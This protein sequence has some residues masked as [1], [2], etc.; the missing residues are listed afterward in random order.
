MSHRDSIIKKNKEL[1]KPMD[2]M[3]VG[4]TGNVGSGGGVEAT[5]GIISSISDGGV[6]Y[7]VHTFNTAGT[8]EVITEGEVEVLLVSGGGGGGGSYSNYRGAGGGGGGGK[9]TD[10]FEIAWYTRK[11]HNFCY[12]RLWYIN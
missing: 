12:Y 7:T 8:F 1:K 3:N 11:C 10:P 6:N 4:F 5:G 9:I 2:L